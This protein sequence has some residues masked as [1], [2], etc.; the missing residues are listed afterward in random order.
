MKNPNEKFHVVVIG[1][2]MS[3]LHAALELKKKGKNVCL[4]EARD[5]VGGRSLNHT[6]KNGDLVDVGGQ[7][8]GPGHDRMPHN[9]PA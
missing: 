6:F 5:R 8:V 1:A 3:G 4:L 9:G 7:W 2:G